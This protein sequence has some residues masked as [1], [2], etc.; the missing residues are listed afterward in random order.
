[1]KWYEAKSIEDLKNIG[2]FKKVK[3]TINTDIRKVSMLKSSSNFIKI[4][5]NSWK[6]LLSNINIFLKVCDSFSVNKPITSNQNISKK[7]DISIKEIEKDTTFEYFL[8]KADEY[9]FYLLE[10]SGEARMKKLEIYKAHYADKKF[11]K[12]WFNKIAKEIHPDKCSNP[13][14]SLAMAELKNLYKRM[15]SE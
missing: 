11:A 12:T 8:S 10:L 7:I 5:S 14:A 6:G 9:I 3:L 1:M 2:N 13:K 4:N 15:I